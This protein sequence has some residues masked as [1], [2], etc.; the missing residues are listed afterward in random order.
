MSGGPDAKWSLV[1][2][3]PCLDFANTVGGRV[4][5]ARRSTRDLAD[6]VTRDDLPDYESLLRWSVRAGLLD[7][8]QAARLR[9]RARRSPSGAAAAHRRA[10]RLRESLYRIGKSLVEGWELPARD[11]GTL[12]AAVREA[13]AHQRLVAAPGR[14]EATW[15]DPAALDRMLW[16][17][18]LSAAELFGSRDL[19]QLKQCPGADCGWLFLD[20]TR[21]HSRQ[22]CEMSVCGNLAKVRRFRQRARRHRA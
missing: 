20:I 2:G 22:W 5:G 19:A 1:G 9:G 6:R 12:D 11:L 3:R 15:T 18:A 13:R 4:G 14:I 10:L 21:N 7:T 8:G 16:P 17:I